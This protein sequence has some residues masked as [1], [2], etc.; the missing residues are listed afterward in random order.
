LD[1]DRLFGDRGYDSDEIC[2]NLIKRG[3]EPA[4]PPLSNR[5]THV[6]YDRKAHKRR[7]LIE[8]CVNRLKQFRRI[9]SRY[10]KSQSLSLDA[11]HRGNKALAQNC[12]RGL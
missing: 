4:I 9:A 5:T 1:P 3:I 12:Q 2:D 6:K 7:N 11:M 8:R 10:E